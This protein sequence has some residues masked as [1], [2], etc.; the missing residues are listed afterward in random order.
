MAFAYYSSAY[1]PIH[2]SLFAIRSLTA[3][4]SPRTFSISY[5]SRSWQFTLS[6]LHIR[7]FLS[8]IL[9]ADRFPVRA[10]IAGK[11]EPPNNRNKGRATTTPTK[12]EEENTLFRSQF[13]D[14]FSAFGAPDNP[15]ERS[16]IKIKKN[17]IRSGENK[18]TRDRRPRNKREKIY[19]HIIFRF[20]G[21]E[22]FCWS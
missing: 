15:N 21:G 9:I 17:K 6:N 11:L 14:Y 1:I 12:R 5:H 22:S 16:V 2:S 7:F 4:W 13:D 3:Q 19:S 8:F 18:S 20:V 10:R